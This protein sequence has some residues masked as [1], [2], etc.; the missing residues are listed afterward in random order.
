MNRRE[1]ELPRRPPGGAGS[2]LGVRTVAGQVLLLQTVVAVL[3]ILAAVFALVLQAR[4]DSVQDGQNRSFATAA[5]MAHAPGTIAALQSPDPTAAL[6]PS[7]AGAAKAAGVDFVSVYAPD[8]TRYADTDASLIGE[9]SSGVERAAGGDAFTEVYEGAPRNATRAVVP[10]VDADGTVIG[11]VGAGVGVETVGSAVDRQLPV[12]LGS[13]A[14]AFVLATVSAALVSRR[15]R[16]QTHGIGPAEMTR[17]YEHHDAVLHAV[18]EGVLIVDGAG[19][20]VLAN[21][22]AR[23]LLDLGPDADGRHVSELGLDPGFVETLVSDEPVTDEVHT[24][25]DRLLAV[26]TRPPAPYGERSGKVATLRDTT[27]LLALSGTAE[28][29]TERL[30]ILYEAGMRI[31]T[32]LDVV[33]TSEELSG[34]AVPRFAD[35][36]TVEL[37]NPVLQGDEPSGVPAEMNRAALT[38]IRSNHPFQP[39]GDVIRFRSPSTPMAAALSGGHAVLEAD[40]RWGT[41]YTSTGKVIWTEQSLADG[42]PPL[43]GA[44]LDDVEL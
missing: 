33:R 39:V 36:T 1:Q 15:L 14:A 42:P 11:L 25:R 29:A 37:L 35:F 38:G 19:R 40:L 7:T 2:L 10:V 22:E 43:G 16:R 26:S 41:R 24:A 17:M 6:Q 32:T 13:A 5:S 23:R 21:D 3:L 28:V 18:R 44:L 12:L 34:A 31:G 30:K 20:L 8:G 9:R 27:E 4:H